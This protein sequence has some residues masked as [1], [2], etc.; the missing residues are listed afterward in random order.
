MLDALLH[1]NDLSVRQATW[2]MNEVMSGNVSDARLAAFLIALRAKGETVEEV[3]GF[4]DAILERAQPTNLPSW[5]V[6][7]VG[8]GGDMVGTV[9]VSTT[10]SFVIAA[11]G[12]PVLKHGNKAASAKSGATDVMTALGAKFTTSV[13]ALEAIFNETHQAF[14]SAA[15]FHPGFK[16]AVNV[17]QQLGIPTVMN[18]LGPLSNPTR[19]EASAIGVAR[20]E[21]I[22]LVVGTLRTRGAAALVFRGD[23]GLDEITV[24][25]YSHIWE[26]TGGDVAEHDIHPRDV[27]LGTYE[28]HELL[29]GTAAENARTLRDT[30]TGERRGGVRDIVLFNAAAGLVSWDLAQHPDHVTRPIRDRFAEQI[31]VAAEAIDSGK[32]V[33]QLDSF[34][35]ATQTYGE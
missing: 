3:V 35:A 2:A 19:P 1:G 11:A 25:G 12:A 9:N 22:P 6:D 32:A 20:P 18:A 7:I 16:H 14:I 13:S 17:R 33:A 31:Q 27:G 10:A 30:L 5:G 24:T 21:A 8:T 23:D 4:R 28:L 34:I 15:L 29:G 26:I